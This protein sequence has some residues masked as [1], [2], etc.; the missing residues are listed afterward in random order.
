MGSGLWFGLSVGFLTFFE[1]RMR[2]KGVLA[3]L[4]DYRQE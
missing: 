3:G 1:A 2:L 4:A